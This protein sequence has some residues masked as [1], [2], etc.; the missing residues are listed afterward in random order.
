MKPNNKK[1]YLRSTLDRVTGNILFWFR[2]VQCPIFPNL[3]VV[4]GLFK[5]D[6][7]FSSIWIR[8]FLLLCSRDVL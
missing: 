2:V 8:L 7:F 3:H 4:M 5:E 1:K 6:V